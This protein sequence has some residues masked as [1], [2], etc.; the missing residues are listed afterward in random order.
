MKAEKNQMKHTQESAV[1][2]ELSGKT[3]KGIVRKVLIIAIGASLTLPAC[4]SHKLCEAY[5]KASPKPVKTGGTI[6]SVH[7]QI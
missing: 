4:T 6:F 3:A 5:S 2:S 1:K 7:P